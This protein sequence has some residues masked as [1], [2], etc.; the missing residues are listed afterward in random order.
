MT[1][2]DLIKFIDSCGA[3]MIESSR[4]HQMP[5]WPTVNINAGEIGVLLKIEFCNEIGC[6]CEVLVGKDIFFD[7]PA[8]K[9]EKLFTS[10]AE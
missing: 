3:I 1:V 6:L 8:A 5:L 10:T 2:G 9:I 7:V 4:C